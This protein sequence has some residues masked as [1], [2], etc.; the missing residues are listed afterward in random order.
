MYG[1][2]TMPLLDALLGAGRGVKDALLARAVQGWLNQRADFGKVTEFR[3]DSRAKRIDVVLELK[4]ETDAV[5]V[6]LH[7]YCLAREGKQLRVE[8]G[9]ITAS[10]EWIAVLAQRYVANRPLLLPIPAGYEWALGLLG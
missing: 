4:G 8:I 5:S 10:R 6:T 9:R 3:L 1:G 7:D 2:N